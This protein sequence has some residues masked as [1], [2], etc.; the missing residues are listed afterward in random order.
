MC[1]RPAGYVVDA[2]IGDGAHVVRID[3]ARALRLGTPVDK[4][5][6]LRH[7]GVVHVVEHDDVGAGFHGLAHLVERFAL[8]LD[9][10]HERG[11]GA[12]RRHGLSHAARGRDVVVLEHDAVGEVVAVIAPAARA[13]GLLLEHA[14]VRRG[15][16]R[17]H[18]RGAAAFKQ[19]R[20]ATCVRGDAAHALQV[21]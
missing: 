7:G 6:G 16:A 15:F 8:H 2:Q 17:V 1:Q 11:V 4:R 20:H 9:L 3:V 18:Q 21:V 19:A 12:C 5:D 13:D 14:H 10:A